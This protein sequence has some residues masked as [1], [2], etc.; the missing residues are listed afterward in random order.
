MT[1]AAIPSNE[2][3]FVGTDGE[4]ARWHKERLCALDVKL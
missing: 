4:P 2:A 1:H 3:Y